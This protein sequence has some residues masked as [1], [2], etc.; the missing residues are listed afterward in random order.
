VQ[1]L[2]NWAPE[3]KS[4]VDTNTLRVL[5]TGSSALRIEAGRDSLAGRLSTIELG[6]LLLREIAQLGLGETIEPLLPDN[7]IERLLHIESWRELGRL[8]VRNDG[9]ATKLSRGGHAGAGIHVHRSG[10]TSHGR[11]F[12]MIWLRRW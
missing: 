4:L 12:R 9:H 6:P 2:D 5:V 11:M 1:N 7:G 8:G 3:L 10:S